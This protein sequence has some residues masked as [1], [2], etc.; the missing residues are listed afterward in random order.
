MSLLTK[1]ALLLAVA[2]GS[3]LGAPATNLNP[4]G[5]KTH[6]STTPVGIGNHI[7]PGHGTHL[8]LPEHL[9]KLARSTTDSG[10]SNS[11]NSAN[12]MGEIQDTDADNKAA[13]PEP[14]TLYT[15][16]TYVP[17]EAYNNTGTTVS[18]S[19]RHGGQALSGG[20]GG[21]DGNEVVK[22]HIIPMPHRSSVPFIDQATGITF[23]RFHDATSQFS[24][25]LAL[26]RGSL[27]STT[28]TTTTAG[29]TI[30]SL[31]PGSSSSSSSTDESSNKNDDATDFIAQLSFPLNATTGM[32][33][34]A[35]WGGISIS[36]KLTASHQ[37]LF[38]GIQTDGFGKV[39]FLSFTEEET[40]VKSAAAAAAAAAADAATTT[41]TAA[42]DAVTKTAKTEGKDVAFK[43]RTIESATSINST[44]LTY[45]FLCEGCLSISKCANA[46]KN[47]DEWK[48]A[49]KTKVLRLGWATGDAIKPGSSSSPDNTPDSLDTPD[50]P[51]TPDAGTADAATEESNEIE[52][53][54]TLSYHRLAFGHM[55][56]D[57]EGALAHTAEEFNSWKGLAMT[58]EVRGF[59]GVAPPFALDLVN[60]VSNSEG[61]SNLDK[62]KGGEGEKEEGNEVEGESDSDSDSDSDCGCESES[63]SDG[64]SDGEDEE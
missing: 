11:A 46:N 12:S 24:F 61:A 20:G 43:I 57:L 35:G 9:I 13:E 10:S 18:K 7:I 19:K 26:S 8:Q 15:N 55:K 2:A 56:I 17:V 38:L 62:A 52:E 16:H 48:A 25:A 40:T 28:T 47:L 14:Q 37:P 64:D 4:G 22:N 42:A 1:A 50:S 39:A 59:E 23:Q 29:S 34:G 60:G 51:D 41:T 6:V 36:P 31:L 3:A 32:G 33:R 63:D 30:G 27:P 54:K 45:T 5:F 44:F 49:G 53:I 21:G 58:E